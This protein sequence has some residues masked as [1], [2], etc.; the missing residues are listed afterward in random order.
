MAEGTEVGKAYVSLE[1]DPAPMSAGLKQ[2]EAKVQQ[3]A[4]QTEKATTRAK[5]GF[6]KLGKSVRDTIKPITSLVGGVTAAIGTFGLFV[7]L[8]ERLGRVI[9]GLNAQGKTAQEQDTEDLERLSTQRITKKFGL[10]L[11]DIPRG[12]MSD[13]E[14]A[15]QSK[16]KRL[17]ELQ[18][19]IGSLRREVASAKSRA[20][21][22][23][24]RG[25]ENPSFLG[26][27]S[28]RSG[29]PM[30]PFDD[31]DNYLDRLTD[32]FGITDPGRRQRKSLASKRGLSSGEFEIEEAEREASN[33]RETVRRR[34][35][36]LRSPP[37]R[38]GGV[39]ISGLGGGNAD[40]ILRELRG[41]R[42][43]GQRRGVDE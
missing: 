15:L 2:G 10:S 31:D 7:S 42:M 29:R 37:F 23:D 12:E 24:A 5:G 18:K 22:E 9:T 28:S 14:K 26:F 40:A 8:G 13:E 33:I 41:I 16:Y 17:A 34:S 36:G 20:A 3:F 21:T 19:E 6:N 35:F 11:P 38:G 32:Y 4:T 25:M 39:P 27:G 43:D 1:A 30:S